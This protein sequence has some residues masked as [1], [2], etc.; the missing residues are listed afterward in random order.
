MH[1]VSNNDFQASS[2]SSSANDNFEHFTIDLVPQGMQPV[3]NLSVVRNFLDLL[4]PN[5]KEF[6]FQTF[7]DKK[8]GGRALIKQF[9][10]E[11]A[12][13]QDELISLNESGAGIF[14][15]VQETNLQ[16]RKAEDITRIRAI[17]ADFDDGLPGELPL[18]PSIEVETSPGKCQYYWLCDGVSF[19]EFASVM[20]RLVQDYAAD[21]GAKD[22]ARVLRVPG[23]LS[24]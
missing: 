24:S 6:S 4:D 19:E 14:V 15:T 8:R 11:L 5:A 18:E 3:I 9:H 7:D 20:E 1:Q 13:I 21:N 17:Y 23:L 16:G 10:S 12:N 22:L 2:V